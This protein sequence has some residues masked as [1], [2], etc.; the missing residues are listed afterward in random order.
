MTLKYLVTLSIVCPEL[1]DIKTNSRYFHVPIDSYVLK[2]L[3]IKMT[4]AWSRMDKE[5]Y[6]RCQEKFTA[7]IA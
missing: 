5:D 3:D 1:K 6:L 2:I 7:C 4:K